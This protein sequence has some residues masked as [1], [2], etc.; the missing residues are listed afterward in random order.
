MVNLYY[1]KLY[2]ANLQF[3]EIPFLYNKIIIMIKTIIIMNM[4]M[5]NIIIIFLNENENENKNENKNKN[6]KYLIS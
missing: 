5:M 1:Q 6:K 3:F 4:I 2:R